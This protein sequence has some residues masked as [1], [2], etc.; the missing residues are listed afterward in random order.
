MGVVEYFYEYNG[1][2]LGFFGEMKNYEC[3]SIELARYLAY[4]T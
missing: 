2:V 4:E 3:I 1:S